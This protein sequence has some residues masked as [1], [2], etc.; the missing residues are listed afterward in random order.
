V[1][2]C[3]PLIVGIAAVKALV[4]EAAATGVPLAR[5]V[6]VAEAY[7]RPLFSSTGALSVG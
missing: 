2:E 3:R 5:P 6:Q 7:T 1:N 4:L